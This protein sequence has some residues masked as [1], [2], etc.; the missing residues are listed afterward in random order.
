M[1]QKRD[2][3]LMKSRKRSSF[4][5]TGVLSML[6]CLSAQLA[7]ANENT[8]TSNEVEVKT[9]QSTI[10]GT[11]LDDTGQ[12]LPGANVVEK[13]TTNGTQTDFDGNYSLNVSDGATLV[14]SYIGFKSTEIAVN[15]QSSVNATL[16]EDA[17]ALDEVIVLGYSTQT[18][19][20][21][22]GSVASVDVSEATKAPVVNAA[23]ALQGRVSGVTVVQNATPGSPPKI[24]IRGFGTSNNTNPLFIIDGLQTDDP[25]VLNSINPNDIDQMNVLKDGAAAIYGAR[26]SN[27]VVIITTKGGGY[28]M[29]K[30]VVSV[31]TYT[32]FST[33]A[34]TPDLLNAQQLGDVLYQ[35]AINDG[36]AFNHPQ[37]GNGSSAVVPSTLNGYTRVVSYDPITRGPASATVNPNGTDW[38]DAITRTAVIQ[39]VAFSVANGE[40]NSKYNL[41][42]NYLNNPGNLLETDYKIGQIRL[43]SEFKIGDKVRIGEHF[44]TAYSNSKGGGG[45][46]YEEAIRSSPLIPLYDD[47]G[48]FAGTGAQGTG[49]SRSPLAQL[50]RQS[51]NFNKTVRILG[52]VYLSAQLMDGLTFKTTIGGTINSFNTR[53]F[54]ALDPEHSEPL[55]VNQLTER[56]QDGYSWTFT[57]TL[58]Y[59]KTFNNSKIDA[60]VGIESVKDGVKGKVVSRTDFLFETPDFYLLNNGSGVPLV[61]EAFDSATSLY[62]L[63]GS[64]TYSYGDKYFV[65]GTLRNDTSSRFTGDNKSATFPSVSAG[66]VVS[67]EDFMS[68]DSALSWFKF[69][70]SWGQL[71]NQ[72]LPASNPTINISNLNEQYGNY[73]IDG[74]SIATGAILSSVG[75]PNLKWETSE[76][77]NAGVELGF[78]DDKFNVDFEWFK[79]TTKD[80]I[81]QDNSLISTTAIDAGAPYVN[82]GN[83]ENTG[84]DVT[85]RYKDETTSGFKYGVDINFSHYKN[86]V[87]D[88]I[89]EFQVGDESYR[90]GAVSRTQ[91]GEAISTFFGREVIGFTDTGRFEYRDVNNDGEINDDD[92]TFIGSPHPDFTYGL[93][94]NLGYKSFD[95]SLFLQGSQGNDIYNYNK[96]YTDFPTFA[97]GNRSVRV[98]DSW[99][100][101]NTDATLPA[102]SSSIQNSETQPNSYFVEDGSYLRL[103]NVQLG[104][105]FS[106]KVANS[107]GLDSFR[108]YIQGTNL[109]TLTGYEGFDPEIIS[110]VTG[111]NLTIGVDSQ[112]VPQS[113]ILT[114]GFNLKL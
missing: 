25:F 71:G 51:D 2:Y 58:N 49:N 31:D 34:N 101:I 12:P 72:S 95:L 38:I 106:D 86:E 30:P 18:R 88:W 24:N 73:A 78:F 96:I 79:I 42:A 45:A 75:N 84:F 102:L 35:S 28:N 6:V 81:V 114:L 92:R 7:Q 65:T 56:N 76:A 32:G 87:T 48:N 22:T 90:G 112:V 98:L 77:I 83:V 85:L 50:N 20:D 13:G 9:L 21:L 113:R 105:A 41:S 89:S 16:A 74:S 69:K 44:S 94:F 93:N 17:A 29:D 37:Y 91:V 33:V 82:A 60:L 3:T 26:A 54:Q 70:G 108:V 109:L 99:T 23:S 39:S 52:D 15:G 66:W 14:F 64:A 27:G 97:D 103:K 1:N 80:L 63:F 61:N 55:G 47:N 59:K 110:S 107:V 57:N 8:S 104:Y 67:K 68:S 46:Q 53:G 62:S 19:G 100:P 10:T 43:N 111:N 40:E 4:I 36:T 11:V 5:K